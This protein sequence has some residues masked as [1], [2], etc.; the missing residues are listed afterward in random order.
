MWSSQGHYE[1]SSQSH[2]DFFEIHVPDIYTDMST[3]CYFYVNRSSCNHRDL[4]QPSD[5]WE[6]GS[7]VQSLS[8]FQGEFPPKIPVLNPH[9][10]FPKMLLWEEVVR[11]D[12]CK[13]SVT[14]KRI[15]TQLAMSKAA[16]FAPF[17]S[18]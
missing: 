18:V 14:K 2:H 13:K 6:F 17:F 5:M 8:P 11:H 3:S 15:T 12:L 4:F 1:G 9:P 10:R 16:C 7:F